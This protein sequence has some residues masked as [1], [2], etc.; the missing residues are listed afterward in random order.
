MGKPFQ[1]TGQYIKSNEIEKAMNNALTKETQ[2]IAAPGAQEL[3]RG[4]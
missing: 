4:L 3:F 1:Q 2:I